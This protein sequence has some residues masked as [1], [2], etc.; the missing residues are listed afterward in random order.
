MI[1]S[2]Q[3]LKCNLL[4]PGGSVGVSGVGCQLM[5]ISRMACHWWRES[6]GPAGTFTICHQTKRSARVMNPYQVNFQHIY[7]RASPPRPRLPIW[8][9]PQRE[10]MAWWMTWI[11]ANRLEIIRHCPWQCWQVMGG[12]PPSACLLSPSALSRHR[13]LNVKAT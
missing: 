13:L 4:T 12:S 1:T 2:R 3:L 10:V 5:L 7:L 6:P 11:A 8:Y 9:G